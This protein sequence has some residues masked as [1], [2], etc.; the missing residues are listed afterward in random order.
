MGKQAPDLLHKLKLLILHQRD[1]EV[2]AADAP[3][4]SR[5]AN[6]QTLNEEAE[7]LIEEAQ[8]LKDN[9][10]DGIFMW[11]RENSRSSGRESQL[12]PSKERR[13]FCEGALLCQRG[14]TSL[15]GLAVKYLDGNSFTCS[16]C[17]LKVQVYRRFRLSNEGKVL[18]SLDL[19]P[20]SHLAACTSL[21]ERSAFYRCVVCY[22]QGADVDFSSPASL[23]RHMALHPDDALL[24]N[25]KDASD[26]LEHDI[27][28]LLLEHSQ[29]EDTGLTKEESPELFRDNEE[30]QRMSRSPTPDLNQR[31]E[32]REE[33]FTV[34]TP[35]TPANAATF[36]RPGETLSKTSYPRSIW[37]RRSTAESINVPTKNEK[38]TDWSPIPS[39][40][41]RQELSTE[42]IRPATP[43]L[44]TVHPKKDV[45]TPD[46]VS[47]LEA[48]EARSINNV[49]NKAELPADPPSRPVPHRAVE[50]EGSFRY[51]VSINPFADPRPASVPT[52]T[53]PP[54]PQ[55]GSRVSLESLDSIQEPYATH[56]RLSQQ[57]STQYPGREQREYVS[58]FEEVEVNV[59]S[60]SKWQ[61]MT[62]PSDHGHGMPFNGMPKRRPVGNGM[63]G[64]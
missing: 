54:I 55:N 52:R 50:S 28:M 20:A 18:V 1:L 43:E 26:T 63:N 39:H 21:W 5:G 9:M 46:N 40:P 45:V 59:S 35:T 61:S 47:E 17:S 3:L 57:F 8:K 58:P 31:Q 49:L 15:D 25:E 30:D 29:H 2:K 44:M 19:F 34:S 41:P 37:S 51:E 48:T 53:P 10:A 16:H 32:E 56:P 6:Q 60:S 33:N 62:V 36:P 12:A 14:K 23:A 64:M 11:L 4:R 22:R 7:A 13:R 38:D 24:L 27:D 42:K